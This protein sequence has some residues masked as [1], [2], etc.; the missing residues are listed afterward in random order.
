LVDFASE[1]RNVGGKNF[2]ALTAGRDSRTICAA[3]LYAGVP[4][5][6]VTLIAGNRSDITIAREICQTSGIPHLSIAGKK[7]DLQKLRQWEQHSL[8][9]YCDADVAFLIPDAQYRFLQNSDRLIRG[10]LFEIGRR[11]FLNQLYNLDW[12]CATGTAIWNRF[13]GQNIDDQL[14]IANLNEW[15][16]WRQSHDN[17]LDLIDN[18]YLDQRIGGWLSSIEQALDMFPWISLHPANSQ[19]AFSALIAPALDL[20]LAA[21]LQEAVI[22]KLRPDLLRFP[23]NPWPSC[24][25]KLRQVYDRAR[26]KVNAKLGSLLSSRDASR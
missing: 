9:S 15:L 18:F 19:V 6:G 22:A 8:R 17:G 23:F 20:R 21:K 24:V 3:L 5:T 2:L 13:Q 16:R 7:R 25:D 26:R 10:G 1:L 12:K 11:Y 4:F 14:S